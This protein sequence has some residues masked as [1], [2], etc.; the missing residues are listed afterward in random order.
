MIRPD[1][2]VSSEGFSTKVL[3][4]ASAKATFFI[5]SKKGEL[6]GAMPAITPSGWRMVMLKR[7]VLVAGK[8]SP[9]TWRARPAATRRHSTA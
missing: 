2:G 9:P 1:S 5:V 4:A 6:N 7:P 8:V 3:P